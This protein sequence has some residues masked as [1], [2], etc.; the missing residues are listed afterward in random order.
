MKAYKTKHHKTIAA[1]LRK[2]IALETPNHVMSDVE[3]SK[4]LQ[5]KG[6]YASK[7]MVYE[8][9]QTARLGTKYERTVAAYKRAAEKKD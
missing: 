9:R 7:A 4:A 5:A 8:V 2:L 1:E 3:L 6:V